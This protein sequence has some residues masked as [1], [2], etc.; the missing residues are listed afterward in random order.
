MRP[1]TEPTGRAGGVAGRRGGRFRSMLPP[2]PPSRDASDGKGPERRPRKRLHWRLDRRL[3]EVARAV[4]G[5][6]CRL[7]M[8]LNPGTV[9]GHRLGALEEGGVSPAPSDASP[10]P[11]TAADAQW[12]PAKA[13][14]APWRRMA[15]KQA[16]APPLA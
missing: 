8:P 15:G 14:S 10:A 7:Q 5:G 16:A 2:P 11:T 12:K 9:A 13:R 1:E 6:Y 3:E 4:G